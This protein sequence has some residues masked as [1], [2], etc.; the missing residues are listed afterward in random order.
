MKRPNPKFV[1]EYLDRHGKPR[2]YFRREGFATVALPGPLGSVEFRA[3]YEA[4]LIGKEPVAAPKSRAVA[5]TVDALVLSYLTS[6]DF[7][8]IRQS[9]Q[10]VY[11]R[12]AE[13]FR[14]KNGH[15]KVAAIEAKHIRA[16]M[17]KKIETPEA[18]NNLLRIVRALMRHAVDIDMRQDN[19]ASA[20][21]KL[22]SRSLGF[23]TWTETE[24]AQYEAKHLIGTRA[25]L[26]FDLLL[27]TAQRRSDIVRM[28]RQHLKDGRIMVIQDKTGKPLSLPVHERLQRSIDATPSDHLTFL[29]TV[30]GN[31]FSPSGFGNYFKDCCRE[32]GLPDHCAAHGIRKL[33]TTRFANAGVTTNQIAAVTGHATLSEVARYTR[34]ANQESMADEAMKKIK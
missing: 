1:K 18:A 22:R 21:R 11:R 13:N 7:L 17:A 10:T 34:A 2:R 4:A 24:I 19:P 9:T 3:A 15:H 14:E 23:H 12:L 32:A 25:R 6:L 30:K 29:T 26:A 28:G 16:L 27:Y 33:A 8:R 5:G 20:V 31:G